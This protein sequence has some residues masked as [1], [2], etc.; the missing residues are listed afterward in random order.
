MPTVYSKGRLSLPFH[1]R[2]LLS[3]NI[4]KVCLQTMAPNTRSGSGS[5]SSPIPNS[6]ARHTLA[7][8]HATD[9][10]E[11]RIHRY[12]VVDLLCIRI[13][14][15]RSRT[16]GNPL[17]NVEADCMLPP[18]SRPSTD[19]FRRDLLAENIP[20]PANAAVLEPVWLG[21]HS[22]THGKFLKG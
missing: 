19:G 17:L 12:L 7:G 9:M 8:T 21:Y 5:G 2:L 1:L 15:V 14:I 3:I 16:E 18:S 10:S 6:H 22:S 20:S 13:N 11:T 4:F